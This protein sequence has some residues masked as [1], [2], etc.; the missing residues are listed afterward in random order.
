MNESALLLVSI[1]LPLLGAI[2]VLLPPVRG[3]V[4]ELTLLVTTI[5][6]ACVGAVVWRFPVQG[7]EYAVTDWNWLSDVPGTFVDVRFSVGLDG[8][9]V[10]MFGLTALLLL[11]SVLVS[12]Q[13][14]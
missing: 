13:A 2:L 1:F 6:L 3:H 14:I 8:L 11:T 9:G 5:T 7:G 4:R 12:W 10:W